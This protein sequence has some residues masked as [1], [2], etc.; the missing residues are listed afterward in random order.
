MYNTRHTT[1][2]NCMFKQRLDQVLTVSLTYSYSLIMS[3]CAVFIWNA[4]S[5][6]KHKHSLISI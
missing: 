4:R 1:E 2:L 6:R 5:H 3:V